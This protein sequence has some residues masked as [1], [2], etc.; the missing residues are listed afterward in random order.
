MGILGI[1]ND[2]LNNVIITAF[3]FLLNQILSV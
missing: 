2:D 3:L 1:L